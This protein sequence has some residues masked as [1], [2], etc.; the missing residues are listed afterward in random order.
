MINNNINTQIHNQ[1]YYYTLLKAIVVG[2][3]ISFILIGFFYVTNAW[4]SRGVTTENTLNVGNVI[5][6]STTLN[7][8]YVYTTPSVSLP[9][10]VTNASNTHIVVRAYFNLYW[11]DG[12][13]LGDV[14]ILLANTNWTIGEDG[15][16]YYNFVLPPQG[17]MGNTAD[18]LTGLEINDETGE[19]LNKNYVVSV[20]FEGAQ[21][22]NLGYANLWTTAPTSWL[23]GLL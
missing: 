22:A 18:F 15:F 11:E 14:S 19:K 6:Q 16:Y 20:Y 1:T 17:T 7:N 5:L 2:F 3:T 4:F 10:S 21:Y 13:P 12:Y 9:V 23:N 8:P